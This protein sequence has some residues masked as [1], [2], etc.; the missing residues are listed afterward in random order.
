MGIELGYPADIQRTLEA[1]IKRARDRSAERV[2]RRRDLPVRNVFTKILILLPLI[3][4]SAD[5]S[6]LRVLA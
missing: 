3:N 6:S 1:G 4:Q 2:T 5:A